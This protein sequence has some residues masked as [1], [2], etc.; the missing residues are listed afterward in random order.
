[1]PLSQY[2]P[3]ATPKTPSLRQSVMPAILDRL[4]NLHWITPDVARS[5]Q[6]YLGFY[7]MFLRS[8]SFRSL[9]NLRGANPGHRWW[10]REK[11]MSERLGV[12]HF[13]VRL[14]SRR[15]PARATLIALIEAF[16]AAPRPVLMKCSGGQDRASFAAALYVLVAGGTPALKEAQAQCALWP[17]LHMPKRQQRW[18]R[19]FPVYAAESAGT[20]R[21]GDWLREQYSPNA[22]ADWLSAR[23]EGGSF[24]AVQTVV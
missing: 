13:D 19:W 3:A 14:S 10:R 24:L 5:A 16:E 7:R 20:M 2:A 11:Q 1:M 15:I 22:F 8:H 4:Y 9:I 17:Y 12:A 21:L 6:P 18:I 23:G